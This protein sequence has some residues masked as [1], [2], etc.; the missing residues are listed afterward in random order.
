MYV[1][2]LPYRLSVSGEWVSACVR[3]CVCACARARACVCVCSASSGGLGLGAE[4]C[5]L[6][7]GR[8][9]WVLRRRGFPGWVTRV[10]GWSQ[11]FAGVYMRFSFHTCSRL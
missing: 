9:A 3:V 5:G 7:A 2:T 1:P 11:R 10:H 4:T 6:L 8:F